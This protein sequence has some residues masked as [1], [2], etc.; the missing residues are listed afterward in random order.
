MDASQETKIKKSLKKADKPL[1][2]LG[3][4]AKVYAKQEDDNVK[5]HSKKKLTPRTLRVFLPMLLSQATFFFLRS[6]S[7]SLCKS[8]KPCGFLRTLPFGDS[9]SAFDRYL[10]VTCTHSHHRTGY[11]F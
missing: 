8:F 11:I 4:T 10:D 1:K 6:F 9:I 3:C 2:R 7:L 5:Q